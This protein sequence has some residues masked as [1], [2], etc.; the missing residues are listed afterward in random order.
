MLHWQCQHT[1]LW[2]AE[3]NGSTPGTA[4]VVLVAC[5]CVVT[6]DLSFSRVTDDSQGYRNDT[7]CSQLLFHLIVCSVHR[8]CLH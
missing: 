7:G 4:V 6:T 2:Y 1:H 8:V 3:G 5:D